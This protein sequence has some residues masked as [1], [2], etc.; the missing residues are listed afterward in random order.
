MGLYFF[1]CCCFQQF[2]GGLGIGN[3][4]VDSKIYVLDS[5][6][7]F[8]GDLAGRFVTRIEEYNPKTDQWHRLPDMPMFKYGFSTVAVDNEIGLTQRFQKP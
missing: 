3:Y 7:R 4:T 1:I 6:A 5:K 8:D 2:S